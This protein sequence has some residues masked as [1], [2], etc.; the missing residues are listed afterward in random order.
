MQRET[1][2]VVAS[3]LASLAAPPALAEPV[4]RVLALAG[5]ASID[6]AGQRQPLQAG[7]E[8]ENGDLIDVGDK[9][10]L[11]VRFADE[12]VVAL[13]ANS[14]LKVQDFRY[15]RNPDDRSI[16]ALIRGGMRT[17]TGLIGKGNPRAHIVGNS[18]AT[19]GIRGTHFTLVACDNDCFNPDG[20]AAA[21]GLFGGVTDGRISV[22]NDAGEAEFGQ[23]DY[24]HVASAA[25]PPERLLA[26]PAVLNDRALVVRARATQAAADAD[27]RA[28]RA[29]STQV[30]TSPQLSA[31]RLQA[32]AV[33]AIRTA[34]AA[35]ERPGVAAVLAAQTDIS[36]IRARS[37]HDNGALNPLTESRSMT[38][39]DIKAEVEGVGDKFFYN[40]A[41][42][43]VQLAKSRVMDGRP[44]AGLYWTF[45][46]PTEPGNPTGTHFVFGDTPLVALPGSGTAVYNFVGGTAPTDNLGRTGSLSAGRLGMDFQTRQ[47]KAL[48]PITLQFA[49]QAVVPATGY[50]VS[51]GSTWNMGAGAQAL[52]GVQ[53][54]GCNG[55]PQVTVNGR[56]VGVTLQGYAA[57]ITVQSTIGAASP[58]N[59]VAAGVAGFGRQ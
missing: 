8:I 58:V 34:I 16:M 47:V 37:V 19:I 13:R 35:G 22:T 44:G 30:S 33:Q 49:R 12:S 57:A 14:Q 32:A 11:Q 1:F 56:L 25:T 59:H 38:I 18:L 9:S 17:L 41:T 7:F 15:G 28:A 40:S 55:T 21:N 42:L 54:V 36:V 23:Q 50:Q 2:I 20:T 53:C 26:P 29:G 24:F 51:A 46:P 4:G 52:S 48:D 39:R 10:A 43:A 31:L 3:L 45:E 6:R 5:T 27:S